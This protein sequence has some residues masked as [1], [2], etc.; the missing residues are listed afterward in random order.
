MKKSLILL[1]AVVG[2]SLASY[3]Q[4]TTSAI[5]GVVYDDGQQAL[6]SATVVAT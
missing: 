5:S 2:F 4:V 6:P 1:F 3:A